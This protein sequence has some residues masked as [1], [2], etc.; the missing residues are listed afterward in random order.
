MIV[1]LEQVVGGERRLD[2]VREIDDALSLGRDHLVQEFLDAAVRIRSEHFYRPT[3]AGSSGR[4][5]APSRP[6]RSVQTRTRLRP[7]AFA[8]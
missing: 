5:L 3:G 8:A 7:P 2:P 4:G 6:R 1:R